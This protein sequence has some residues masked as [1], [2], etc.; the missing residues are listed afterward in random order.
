MHWENALII[1]LGLQNIS[2]DEFVDVLLGQEKEINIVEDSFA[3][4]IENALKKYDDKKRKLLIAK[5]VNSLKSENEQ[6][7]WNTLVK[8][9]HRVPVDPTLYDLFI[10]PVLRGE[11]QN[12]KTEK[13]SKGRPS[14]GEL[15]KYE[16]TL[17]VSLLQRCGHKLSEAYSIVGKKIFKDSD[18]VRKIY[19][20]MKEKE[21]QNLK[22]DLDGEE[23]LKFF[24]GYGT[25]QKKYYIEREK[26]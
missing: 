25:H 24:K 2:V 5:L 10:L 17:A 3:D 4:D 8:L 20:E 19:R 22:E 7:L 9:A 6:W 11:I 26:E 23:V 15:E 16:I 12:P 21:P 13:K 14:R 18:T 1:L